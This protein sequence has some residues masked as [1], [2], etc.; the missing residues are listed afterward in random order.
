MANI[1]TNATKARSDSRDNTVIHSEIRT[2]ESAVLSNIDAGL[3]YANVVSNSTMT[4]SNV[5]YYVYNAITVD[6]TK[7]DQINYVKKYFVD[8]GYGVNILTNA[9][10]NNTI[11]WNISW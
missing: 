6:L 3:L 11:T 7:T 4:N 9:S 2:I 1:F 5:Y 10:S 8:L